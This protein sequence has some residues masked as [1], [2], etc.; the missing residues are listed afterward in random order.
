MLTIY[1]VL[2]FRKQRSLGR[3]VVDFSER[4]Q[5]W[6]ILKLPPLFDQ[7]CFTRGTKFFFLCGWITTF[8]VAHE[9][10]FDRTV[11]ETGCMPQFMYRYFP[12]LRFVSHEMVG[13]DGGLARTEPEAHYTPISILPFRGA[14]VNVCNA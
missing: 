9:A 13:G 10:G 2:C 14:N 7:C 11:R 8:R 3:G 6:D 12:E 1:K 4:L 5:E